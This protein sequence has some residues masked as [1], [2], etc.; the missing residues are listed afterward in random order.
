MSHITVFPHHEVILPCNHSIFSLKELTWSCKKA[1]WNGRKPQWLKMIHSIYHQ[2]SPTYFLLTLWSYSTSI[3]PR[4][5]FVLSP[6]PFFF[7]PSHVQCPCPLPALACRYQWISRLDT[8]RDWQRWFAVGEAEAA[9]TCVAI[10]ADGIHS[11]PSSNNISHTLDM[12][13]SMLCHH[14]L[15]LYKNEAKQLGYKCCHRA[16][17]I[18]AEL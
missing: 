11:D 5:R 1:P 2:Q 12:N 8:K 16:P 15:Q 3:F 6:L 9:Q 14:C 4:P 13:K 18:R 7:E 10:Q 17:V